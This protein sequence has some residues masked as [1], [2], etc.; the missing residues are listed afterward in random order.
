MNYRRLKYAQLAT[1]HTEYLHVQVL[2]NYANKYRHTFQV[3]KFKVLFKVYGEAEVQTIATHF[4]PKDKEASQQLKDEWQN[5]KHNLL[6]MKGMRPKRVK[7]GTS[8]HTSIAWILLKVL[9]ERNTYDYFF[10]AITKLADVSASAPITNASPEW[11]DSSLKKIK[12]KSR[13]RLSQKMQV[14]INGPE[15]GTR[16]AQVVI[17]KAKEMWV[18][19]KPPRKLPKK[20]V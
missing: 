5:F 10:P 14:S 19:A 8:T 7:A 16:E 17:K 20:V 3:F 15:P 2:I 1:Y 4:Y 9:S 6:K 11:A 13:N 12:T 18:S